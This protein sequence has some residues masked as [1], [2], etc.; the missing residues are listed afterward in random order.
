MKVK[1]KKVGNT[2][3]LIIPGDLVKVY[4]F[5]KEAELR[6]HSKGLL[7]LPADSKSRKSWE[8]QFKIAKK[9]GDNTDKALLEGFPNQ[10]DNEK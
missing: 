7:I 2:K 9:S 10:F 3:V 8:H 5:D 4:K 1:L 6:P